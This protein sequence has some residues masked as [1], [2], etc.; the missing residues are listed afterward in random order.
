MRTVPLDGSAGEWVFQLN[1]MVLVWLLSGYRVRECCG[2]CVLSEGGRPLQGQGLSFWGTAILP[3]AAA[4]W[5][6]WFSLQPSL[7]ESCRAAST[8]LICLPCLLRLVPSF[9]L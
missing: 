6:H 9:V 2:L 4:S 3:V 5:V 7:V 1:V 8:E